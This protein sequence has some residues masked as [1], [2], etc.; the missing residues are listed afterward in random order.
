MIS[1]YNIFNAFDLRTAVD[2]AGI[3][4]NY[5]FIQKPEF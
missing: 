2:N 1:Y 4:F 5:T 3:N